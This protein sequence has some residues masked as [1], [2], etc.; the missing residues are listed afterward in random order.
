MIRDAAVSRV[1]RGLGFSTNRDAVIVEALQDAQQTLE[2]L[3]DLPWFLK[4][5]VST[6]STVSGEERV[7]IPS[8]FLRE[9]ED[10]AM[11]YFNASAVEDVDKWVELVKDDADLLRKVL[12]GTGS[13]EAYALSGEYFRI[14]PT[15]DDVYPLRMIYFQQ[16]TLLT[17]NIENLW[18]KHFPLL[19]VGEAGA[20]IAQSLHDQGATQR[21][22][23]LAAQQRVFLFKA[24]QARQHENRRY[25]MGGNN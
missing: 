20:D 2:Q 17:T 5:E 15:P 4:T 7:P 22:Q 8:D 9:N 6:I 3:D 21:F 19:L 18:L 16:D 10:D 12:S 13:P 25:V 23:L 14:F 24:N 1:K 11:Y